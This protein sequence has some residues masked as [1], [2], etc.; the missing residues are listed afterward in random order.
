MLDM[1]NL[2]DK[3]AIQPAKPTKFAAPGAQCSVQKPEQLSAEF[4]SCQAS[5]DLFRQKHSRCQS[6]FRAHTYSCTWPSLARRPN[7]HPGLGRHVELY[8]EDARALY[9]GASAWLLHGD[10]DRCLE[11]LSRALAIDPEETTILYNA[12]CTYSLL[13]EKHEP[14]NLLEKAVRNG[15]GHKEWLRKRSGFCFSA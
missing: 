5:F 12:A 15:Y 4:Q 1:E 9:L 2:A 8:P 11:W 10:R 14:L 13:G 6:A 3:I 7:R